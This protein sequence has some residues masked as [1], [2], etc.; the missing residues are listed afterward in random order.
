MSVIVTEEEKLRQLLNQL[1]HSVIVPEVEERLAE[2]DSDR[3]KEWVSNKEA[4]EIL[5]KSKATLQRWRDDGI[6][7]YSKVENS[8]FYRYDDI[9]ALLEKHAVE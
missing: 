8:I 5:G 1:L 2:L 7:P 6:L 4:L 9:V 3:E